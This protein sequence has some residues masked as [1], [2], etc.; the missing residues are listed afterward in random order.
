[1]SDLVNRI[2]INPDQCGGRPCIRGM[3]IRV[4]DVLELLAAGLSHEQL[5]DE[6]PDLEEEDILASLQYAARRL[7]HPV[8][9]A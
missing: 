8:L 6:M 7:N 4:V 3:R 9:A 5:L 1:M 2:T